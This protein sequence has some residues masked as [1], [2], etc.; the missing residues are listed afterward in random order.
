VGAQYSAK[1]RIFIPLLKRTGGS[2][3]LTGS[4]LTRVKNAE[5]FQH[6]DTTLGSYRGNYIRYGVREHGMGAIM[7]GIAAYGGILPYAGTFL[8]SP[9]RQS[10]F[11]SLPVMF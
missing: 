3:D 2:A 7:N 6:P 9:N 11:I 1:S 5:D 10:K 8:V 4:N